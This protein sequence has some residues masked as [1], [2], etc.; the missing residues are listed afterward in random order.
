[1]TRTVTNEHKEAMQRGRRTGAAVDAYLKAISRPKA[2]GRKVSVEDMEQRRAAAIEEAATEDGVAK[3]KLLQRAAD[4]EKR[5][6]AAKENETVDIAP[7]E[8]AFIEVASEYS[9]TQGIGY[10]TW[11]DV[12]VSA[13]VLKAAGIKQTRQRS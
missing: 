8:T 13:V 4:L 10:S 7:L 1:M 2:R 12:G 5:I 6:D 11:R 3:L 9:E